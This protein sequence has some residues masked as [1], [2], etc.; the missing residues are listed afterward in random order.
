LEKGLFASFETSTL[1]P[2]FDPL[3]RE[4]V[5]LLA[6]APLEAPTLEPLFG[7]LKPEQVAP[8]EALWEAPSL[9]L[10]EVPL[11]VELFA[12]CETPSVEPMFAPL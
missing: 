12:P 2:L 1:K 7:P 5:S 4:Q 3:E 8:L 6:F 10:T 9:E 11:K